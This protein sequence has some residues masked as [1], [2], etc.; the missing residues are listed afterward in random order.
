MSAVTLTDGALV[1]TIHEAPEE[2]PSRARPFA[3]QPDTLGAPV[4]YERTDALV[5]VPL[6]G[7]LL[8]KGD[9]VIL[10]TWSEEGALLTLTERDGTTS[11][12]WRVKPGPAPRI[13]RKDGDSADWLVDLRLWRL[14]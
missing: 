5:E 6:S 8:T 11:P 12:G 2:R 9:V 4:I 13:R 3:L 1:V 14:P 10:E 7:R